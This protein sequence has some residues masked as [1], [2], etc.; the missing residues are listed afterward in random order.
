[1]IVSIHGSDG[2]G[3]TRVA[4]PV[5]VLVVMDL[6]ASFLVSSDEYGQSC[7]RSVHRG[8][9]P[10]TVHETRDL[11]CVLGSLALLKS[12]R[13]PSLVTCTD[14]LRTLAVINRFFG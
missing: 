11:D 7:S 8:G 4:F 2:C 10:H 12:I 5:Q 6:C 9:R 1:M 13:P 14:Q 3:P